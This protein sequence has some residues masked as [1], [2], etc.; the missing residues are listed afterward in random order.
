[1]PFSGTYVFVEAYNSSAKSTNEQS[2]RLLRMPL[3][4]RAAEPIPHLGSHSPH[5]RRSSHN[6][7]HAAARCTVTVTKPLV[8]PLMAIKNEALA[9]FLLDPATSHRM[10]HQGRLSMGLP[11]DLQRL[12]L[13]LHGRPPALLN[14]L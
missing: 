5:H 3:H 4:R 8:F 7:P 9:A 14:Y 6:I 11:T 1:M 10:F 2:S 12:F 13:V